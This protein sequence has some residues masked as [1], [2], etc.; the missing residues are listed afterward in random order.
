M[1]SLFATKLPCLFVAHLKVTTDSYPTSDEKGFNGF[2]LSS[3]R[4]G[5]WFNL[6][7]GNGF[8]TK[9][10][11]SIAIHLLSKASIMARDHCG[12]KLPPSRTASLGPMYSAMPVSGEYAGSF[13][14]LH[15][16]QGAGRGIRKLFGPSHLSIRSSR[17]CLLGVSSRV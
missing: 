8:S 16:F 1:H 6:S 5:Q 13:S 11:E 9:G 17:C 10:V 2:S 12:L 4:V 14:A 7:Q 3:L 15:V